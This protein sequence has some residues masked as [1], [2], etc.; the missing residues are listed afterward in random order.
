MSDAPNESSHLNHPNRKAEVID[1]DALIAKWK[2]EF[3]KV[4]SH[5]D[6][7]T[8]GKVIKGLHDAGELSKP[9]YAA[10]CGLGKQRRDELNETR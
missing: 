6:L 4:N 2:R 8:V 9:E 3:A 10:I 5:E 7:N 1:L